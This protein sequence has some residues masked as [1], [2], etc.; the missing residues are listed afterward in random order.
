MSTSVKILGLSFSPR[1]G[2]TEVILR[3]AL[4]AA[5]ELPG[6]ETDY[7]DSWKD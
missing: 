1:H 7:Y 2:N 3:E 4:R 5:E 6:V